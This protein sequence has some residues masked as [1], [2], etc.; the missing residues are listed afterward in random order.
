MFLYGLSDGSWGWMYFVHLT[1]RGYLLSWTFIWY[2]GI[3]VF[4][5]CSLSIFLYGLY[6]VPWESCAP[7]LWQF[8]S[9]FLFGLSLGAWGG[10]CSVTVAFRGN[11]LTW[12]FTWWLRM[13]VLRHCGS[14]TVPRRFFCH[15]L[16]C[17]SSSLNVC[18]A[19]IFLFWVAILPLCGKVT[20]RLA[21]C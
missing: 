21:F 4:R 1:F 16:F 17:Y 7:S 6:F 14:L 13:A 9:I 2:L 15:S 5:H 8:V 12:T 18:V 19:Y 20:V 11:L 3:T 10:L